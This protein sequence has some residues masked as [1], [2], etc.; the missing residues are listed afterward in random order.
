[1]VNWHRIE[2][3]LLRPGCGRG[4]SVRLPELDES[5]RRITPEGFFPV[6]A[7]CQADHLAMQDV[8]S[9]DMIVPHRDTGIPTRLHN[10]YR[11][12]RD[13]LPS[14]ADLLVNVIAHEVAETLHVDGVRVWDPHVDHELAVVDRIFRRFVET[15]SLPHVEARFPAVP[16]TVTRTRGEL[17]VTVGDVVTVTTDLFELPSVVARAWETRLVT[18]VRQGPDGVAAAGG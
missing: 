18:L 5:W 14:A 7:R 17:H 6:S 16:T 4:L 12:G 13:Y 9:W 3:N 1:M 8:F 10:S 11:A 2:L 15:Q